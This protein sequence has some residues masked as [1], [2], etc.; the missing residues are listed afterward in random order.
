MHHPRVN[1]A[2]DLVFGWSDVTDGYVI[3]GGATRSADFCVRGGGRE[4]APGVEFAG[5]EHD[6]GG[7]D[8]PAPIFVRR[9]DIGLG[10][11][12]LGEGIVTG[13]LEDI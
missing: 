9:R 7:I 3:D 2:E 13:G 10:G 8:V 5:G 6:V 4:G 11:E 1:D 12:T